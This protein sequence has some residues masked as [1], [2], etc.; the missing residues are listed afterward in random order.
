M[1]VPFSAEKS[2][3]AT[4]AAWKEIE[5][6]LEQHKERIYAQ[7][8]GYPTPITA[9]DQ[10]FNYLLDERTAIS[11]ELDRLRS[12]AEESTRDGDQRG[13]IQAFI[14]SSSYVDGATKQRLRSRLSQQL[15]GQHSTRP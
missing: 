8:K 2:A 5:S 12:A 14:D 4:R 15:S 6:C 3:E 7:I 10:Q 13:C 11:R 9:C 1:K